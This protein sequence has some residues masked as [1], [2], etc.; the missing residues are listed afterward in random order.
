M[1]L[2]YPTSPYPELTKV[3]RSPVSGQ[4]KSKHIEKTALM[5]SV[6]NTLLSMQLGFRKLHNMLLRLSS[7]LVISM[8]EWKNKMHQHDWVGCH[9]HQQNNNSV[10]NRISNLG[11][12]ELSP[13]TD[14]V[15]YDTGTSHLL[16]KLLWYSNLAQL[17][18]YNTSIYLKA[19]VAQAV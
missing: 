7:S 11:R 9:P 8:A 18:C 3:W 5:L 17:I 4:H 10:S 19:Q 2:S 15:V 1:A 14:D 6:V 12:Q 16:Q 13:V